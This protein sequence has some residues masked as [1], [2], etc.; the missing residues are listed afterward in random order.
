MLSTQT[1][2]Q[3]AMKLHGP[4]APA[5]LISAVLN[6]Q[7]TAA[8]KDLMIKAMKVTPEEL[9][10]AFEKSPAHVRAQTALAETMLKLAVERDRRDRKVG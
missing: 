7:A 1:A 10:K 9:M 8:H 2:A 6:S 4:S 5:V 3:V